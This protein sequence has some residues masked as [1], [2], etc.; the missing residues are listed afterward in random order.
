MFHLWGPSGIGKTALLEL[1]N[2]IYAPPENII[3]FAATPI[4]I[5]ILSERLSGI[6]LIIDEKQ[7]TFDDSKISTLIYSLAE[8]RTRMKATKES[9]LITNKKFE[10]NVITSGEEPLNEGKGT[11]TGASRRT[12]SFYLNKIFKDNKSSVDAHNVC[13]EYYGVA[14][15]KFVND[16]IDTYSE[17]DY[18][19]I[20]TKYE[21]I[22]SNLREKLNNSS[23][24][25][26]IQSVSV[27][28][29]TDVLVNKFFEFGFS[30]ED[31]LELGIKILNQLE[32]EKEIDEIERAKEIIEDWII[33]NDT[34]F[35]RQSFTKEYS[36][37]EDKNIMTEI[38]DN[39]NSDKRLFQSYGMYQNGVYYIIPQIFNEVLELNKLSPKK[40][41][42]C[43]A[44]KGY[45]KIDENN[46]K[47]T[48]DKY[49]RGGNRRMIAYFLVND[50]K[51]EPEEIEKDTEEN[52]IELYREYKYK[53]VIKE[54]DVEKLEEI[55]RFGKEYYNE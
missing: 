26:Y 36:V 52:E 44:E 33:S 5:T 16:L 20:R 41:R 3:T 53:D 2:S 9:D 49:Y 6:G 40:V 31:S 23:S 27:I 7:S 14:G 1:A 8:G 17:N 12:V 4:S 45:I 11:H 22:E 32:E 50:N 51:V 54:K 15:E 24:I 29:L 21:E 18:E 37:K 34:M 39:E 38:L 35:E 55:S 43:F 25:P 47:Y 42:K 30:E 28:I 48:V 13:K 19:D 46:K 10:I